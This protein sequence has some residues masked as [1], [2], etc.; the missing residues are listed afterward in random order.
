MRLVLFFALALFLN[1]SNSF[2]NDLIVTFITYLLWLI[3]IYEG[4]K[5]FFREDNSCGKR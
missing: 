4:Y 3:T 2:E 5:E 1:N